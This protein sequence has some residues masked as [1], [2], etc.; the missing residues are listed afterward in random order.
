MPEKLVEVTWEQKGWSGCRR[1]RAIEDNEVRQE[2]WATRDLS[3]ILDEVDQV[4][5]IDCFET[6]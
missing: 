1:L 5:I 2:M 6:H 4:D 3:V